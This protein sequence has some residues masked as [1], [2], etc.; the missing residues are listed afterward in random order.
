MS[1]SDRFDRR[2]PSPSEKNLGP[3]A[4]QSARDSTAN[5]ASGSVDHCSFIFQQHG[6]FLLFSSNMM[7]SCCYYGPG[8]LEDT[9][10]FVFDRL[11]PDRWGSKQGTIGGAVTVG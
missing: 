1:F 10:N 5:P 2:P 6:R 7:V 8:Q 4:R 3:L 9:E 11:W